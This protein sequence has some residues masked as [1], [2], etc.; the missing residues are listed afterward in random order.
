MFA[1]DKSHL[2]RYRNIQSAPAIAK[3]ENLSSLQTVSIDLVCLMAQLLLRSIAQIQ[4]S[5]SRG[6]EHD[7]TTTSTNVQADS[8]GRHVG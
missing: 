2:F 7:P 8:E 4:Y 1:L 6:V 3:D 5:W